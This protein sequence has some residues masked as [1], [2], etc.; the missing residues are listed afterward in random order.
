M[1]RYVSRAV[2][3]A[4]RA[5]FGGAT[6]YAGSKSLYSKFAGRKARKGRAVT[7]RRRQ[8]K[9]KYGFAS[10]EGRVKPHVRK[11]KAINSFP[12]GL[13]KSFHQKVQKS[14][15]VTE[16]YGEYVYVSGVQQRQVVRDKWAI[17]TVDQNGIQYKQ[18]T[19][20]QILDAASVCFNGKVAQ[21]NPALT[22][23]NFS[24]NTTFYVMNSYLTL[25]FKS[26]S[27][28]VVNIEVYECRPKMLHQSSPYAHVLDTPLDMGYLTSTN[29][30]T[31]TATPEDVGT[32][33]AHWLQLHSNYHVKVHTMKILPG[34][35]S[36]LFFQGPK[37]KSVDL[38][39]ASIAGVTYDFVP[40]LSMGLFF[41]VI[42][43]VSVSQNTGNIYQYPSNNQGGVAMK[44]ER[45]IRLRPPH[46]GG[47]VNGARADPYQKA[48]VIGNFPLALADSTDQQVIESV[49]YTGGV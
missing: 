18:F 25:F 33:S 29:G 22:P 1:K 39:K 9:R 27:N 28:H 7:K 23:G 3:V 45:V 38:A 21:S 30:V 34:M 19:P 11:T 35:S 40:G 12:K 8:V 20:D 42:N 31:A 48:V 24:D 6:A 36:S 44:F 26:T 46:H 41:R 14:L 15:N 49:I 5:G 32:K 4:R 13:S 10:A 16:V 17:G 43:D 2:R 37:M 47:L